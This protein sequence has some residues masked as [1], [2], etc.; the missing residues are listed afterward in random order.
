MVSEQ[1]YNRRLNICGACK[2][3]NGN[4]SI[5]T[6]RRDLGPEQC[7]I[8]ACNVREKAKEADLHCADNPPKW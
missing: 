5:L 8:C 6:K 2:K 3:L 7:I 4:R 1:E